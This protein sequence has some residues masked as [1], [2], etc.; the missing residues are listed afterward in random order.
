M[1]GYI[2]SHSI[3]PFVWLSTVLELPIIIRGRKSVGW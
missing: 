2:F 1:G 3:L